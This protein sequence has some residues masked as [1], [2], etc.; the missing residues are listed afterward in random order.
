MGPKLLSFKKGETTYSLRLFPI[1]GYCAMEGE[2]EDS[3]NPRAFN[4]AKI[5]KRMIIIVAGAFMNI[6]FGLILMV[7]TLLPMD[8]FN[9]TTISAFSPYSFTATTGLQ[10]GD[11]IIEI[12]D[13]DINSTMD[14]SFAM[15]TMPLSKVDGKAVSIYKQDCLFELKDSYNVVAQK[16]KQEQVSA[17][18]QLWAEGSDKIYKTTTKESAYNTLCEYIDKA[19]ELCEIEKVSSYPVIEEKDSRLRFRSDIVVIRDGEEVTLNDV[20][21]LTY[22]TSEDGEPTIGIDFFVEPIEKTFSSV[23]SQ[24]FIQT[25]SVVRTVWNSLVGLITGQFGINEVAGPVGLAYTI[26]DVAGESLKEGFSD[27]VMSIVYVMM[28]ISI[29][30]GIVNMLPFPALDGGRFVLLIIEA[31]FKK[32]VPRRIEGYINAAGL[33]LL[34]LLMAVITM[35][36]VWVYVFGG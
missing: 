23:I 8:C 6:V 20:D 7:I 18:N 5:W 11:E 24:T 35:K 9:S 31:I 17:L 2:D 16:A 10:Q 26:T 21:F 12:N 4:N 28:V 29:N 36:D 27:A 14:F 30:L 13:Y 15:Y 33:I 25:G 1:G 22:K 32:P 34:L 19:Y 3:D